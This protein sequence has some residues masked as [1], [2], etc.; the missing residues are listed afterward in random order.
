[1][2]ICH[3]KNNDLRKK[4]KLFLKKIQHNM[5]LRHFRPKS[6][7]DQSVAYSFHYC[8][9]FSSLKPIIKP[10]ISKMTPDCLCKKLRR[11]KSIQ[12]I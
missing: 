12:V 3:S 6:W 2:S 9:L 1:M 4:K 11:S 5:S 10:I 8:L 7:S